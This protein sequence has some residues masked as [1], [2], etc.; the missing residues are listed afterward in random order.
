MKETPFWKNKSLDEMSLDQWES[1]CDGCAR[2]C[3]NQ[4]EDADTGRVQPVPVACRYLDISRCRCRIYAKRALVNPDCILMT[5]DNL[6]IL[7]WL[8]ETCAY[9]CIAEGK[10]LP[11]WHPLVSGNPLSV[12]T[13]GISVQD[14]V[15]SE[16]F[17]HP[18]DLAWYAGSG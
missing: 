14:R 5:P 6:S 2:C 16:A 13:A 12:H 17:V 8:P 3:L 10:D 9:R 18:E 1:L 4:F 7:A 11:Q 15:V